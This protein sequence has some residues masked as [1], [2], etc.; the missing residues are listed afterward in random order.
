MNRLARLCAPIF[1]L[2][3]TLAAGLPTRADDI[4]IYSNPAANTLRPPMTVLVL[5][6]NLLGICNNVL[7]T[8]APTADVDN[9]M[10]R[11]ACINLR[12][13][14][15]L[16]GL[17]APSTSNPTQFLSNLLVGSS[18]GAPGLCNLY[19]L[20]GLVSPVVSLPNVGL[21]TGL[22][23]GVTQLSC[24]TL[25]FLTGIPLLANVINGLLPGFTSQLIAGLL[26]PLLS[27]VVG[28]LP[29]A[30]VGLVNGALTA[31]QKI[32]ADPL[33]VNNLIA[34][35][36]GLLTPLINSR[37]AIV[38][39]HGN[40]S[41]AA[42]T[43]VTSGSQSYA[44]SFADLASIPSARRTTPNCSNGAYFLLGFTELVGTTTIASVLQLVSNQLLGLL[45]PANLINVLGS[46][47]GTLTSASPTSLTPPFQGKEIYTEIAHY[48]AGD[49]V[50]NAP[51]RS[52]DSVLGLLSRD[53]SIEN[54]GNYRQPEAAC[55]TVNVVNIQLTNS[56]GDDDSDTEA[57][58]Y[59]PGAVQNG[60]ISFPN[61]V[62]EAGTTGFTDT[63]GRRIAMRSYFVIQENLSSLAALSNVGANVLTYGS[64]VGLLNLGQTVA[65]FIAPTLVVNASLVTPRV[66]SSPLSANG[67]LEPA[68]FA[69][70]QPRD[71]QR[72]SW[73]GN[74]KALRF[75]RDDDGVQRFLDAAGN[76][77]IAMDGRIATTALTVGTRGGAL[78]GAGVDGRATG[79]G[80]VG[81]NIPGYQFGGGGN[82]GR[83]NADGARQIFYDALSA[84][85]VPSLAALD[86]DT[87]S[88]RDALQ[89]D[90]GVVGSGSAEDSLRRALL[91]HARGFN[92]G[93]AAAPVGSGS[94][95]SGVTGRPWM[96]GAVLHSQPV[97]VNYGARTGFTAA[98]P[99]LRLLFG[100]AD[101][102]LHSVKNSNLSE[103]WAFMPRAVMANLRTLRDDRYSPAFPYG[104]D[105]A[106][107]V[108]IIDRGTSLTLPEGG[109]AD[110][111]INSANPNDHVYAFF[112]L[113]R[114]GKHRY[115]LDITDPDRPQLIWRIGPDGLFSAN[116]SSPGLV[117]GSAAQ[118]AELA[119]SFGTPA[120]GRMRISTAP[121]SGITRP[122]LLFGGGYNGGVAANGSRIAKDANTSRAATAAAAV[123]RDDTVGNAIFIVDAVSGELIWK[124]ARSANTAITPYDA[125]TRSFRHPLLA[126]S[127]ASELTAL[128]T[129][130]DGLTDRVY[131]GDTGGR[132]WRADF[133]GSNRSA[134]TLGPIAS[135]G[136]SHP[137]GSTPADASNADD[138]RFFHAPDYVP[139]RDVSGSFDAVVI[140][141]GDRE[142]PFNSST[143]NWL[144]TVRDRDT[145]T[146]KSLTDTGNNGVIAE[147][148]DTRLIRQTSLANITT[149]CAAVGTAACATGATASSGWRLQL[150]NAGEKAVSA[151]VTVGN[152]VTLSSFVPPAVGSTSCEPNEGSSRLYGVRL[153]DGR[154]AVQQ[155]IDDGDA[156][157]RSRRAAAPGIAGEAA[158]LTPQLTAINAETLNTTVPLIYRTFWRER[159]EDEEK[160]VAQ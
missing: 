33:S 143:G 110:G 78:G 45:D 72:P 96:L 100:S 142:D 28:A 17:L 123:G 6:L 80:G 43:P 141:S 112:G 37:V 62:R 104:V 145:S 122:V 82:P 83:V 97:A 113:R 35:I 55:D 152:V 102:L 146:G 150:A 138:R 36:G 116:A 79:L 87:Q 107:S 157:A 15:S 118:F 31:P 11:T 106:P 120:V 160:P 84:T 105:G 57:A 26:N 127:I 41:N 81:Q 54:G 92:V 39:S 71:S 95:F 159:R 32:L 137:L 86:A 85:N 40:R 129:D 125:G 63:S 88:V 148:S 147:E 67:L 14:T 151:P 50:Y 3:M 7:L 30:V 91:L 74:V 48:L 64:T 135:L 111:V 155:F 114:G 44:C 18:L 27:T 133:P 42:G 89:A 66:A 139:G 101:G 22:L 128:D 90:L 65:E 144:Y 25:T 140:G 21:L 13:S 126:D 20:L 131:V 52:W 23:G 10:G 29:A 98:N 158:A 134:W 70:F 58:R 24:S 5:D 119:L 1:V 103:T 73:L 51:L 75:A 115:A 47:L 38:V 136:R 8:P 59:F 56:I 132:I 76:N 2:L 9:P 156:D 16:L 130:G 4:D 99:D 124:A 19:N 77:A 12:A 61:L 34:V 69:Q 153:L 53:T 154:P 49:V 117:S 60:A 108:L 109:P 93:T 46:S 94:G 149:A 68:Y 121:S